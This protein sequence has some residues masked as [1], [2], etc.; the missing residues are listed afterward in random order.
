MEEVDMQN[1]LKAY[2]AKLEEA[3]LLNLQSWALNV[4][5]FATLQGQKAESKLRSLVKLKKTMVLLGIVYVLF[6]GV[7]VYGNQWKN[8][9]FSVSIGAIMLVTIAAIIVYVKHIVLINRINYSDNIA[10]TQMKLS[11]LQAST[12]N[13]V[14]ILWLQLPFHTTWFW[15]K[16]WISFDRLTC[17][18]TAFPITILFTLMAI[19]LY[20]NINLD[21]TDKK[22]FKILFGTPEWTSV[23][24][25]KAFLEEVEVFTQEQG[26]VDEIY[27]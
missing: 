21:N 3:T 5:C 4:R 19:W 13:I 27:L 16:E 18:L 10:E 11:Q 26:G 6:L 24:K 8:A 22:W 14:R 20:R 12:V 23:C 15:S 25:A 17:W 9:Y 1:I 7:L 2:D